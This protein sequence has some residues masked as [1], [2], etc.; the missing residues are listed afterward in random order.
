LPLGTSVAGPLHRGNREPQLGPLWLPARSM[1]K[2]VQP[3]PDNAFISHH[4]ALHIV[5]LVARFIE[6]AVLWVIPGVLVNHDV[7]WCSGAYAPRLAP[8]IAG[9]ASSAGAPW[10]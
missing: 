2:S 8:A 10:S 7:S 6:P 5:G 9:A 3:L 1:E 4:I